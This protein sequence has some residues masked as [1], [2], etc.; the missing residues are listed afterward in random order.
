MACQPLVEQPVQGGAAAYVTGVVD[1]RTIELSGADD[2]LAVDPEASASLLAVA[3]DPI[4]WTV[5]TRL[6]TGG[7]L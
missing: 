4:R 5:L 2:V 3:A 6:A 1:T 7:S